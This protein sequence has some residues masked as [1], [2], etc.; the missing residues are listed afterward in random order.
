LTIDTSAKL[1]KEG[2]S[3]KIIISGNITNEGNADLI[4]VTL[5]SSFHGRKGTQVP[6]TPLVTKNIYWLGAGETKQFEMVYSAGYPDYLIFDDV[7]Q[8]IM[9]V[10][11]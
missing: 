2:L 11:V 8:Y 4:V 5:K 3:K 10:C 6:T 1:V 7:L 9:Y